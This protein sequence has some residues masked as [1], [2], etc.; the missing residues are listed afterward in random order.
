MVRQQQAQAITP[1]PADVHIG[2]E[3][4]A[5]AGT[6]EWR[7]LTWIKDADCDPVVGL[8]AALSSEGRGTECENLG[9]PKCGGLFLSSPPSELSSLES[10]T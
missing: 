3:A 8:C 1:P 2:T 6:N 7:V 5:V 4:F 9:H 10:L